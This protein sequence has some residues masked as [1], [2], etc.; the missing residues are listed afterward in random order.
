[1]KS[2]FLFVSKRMQSFAMPIGQT[3]INEH[4]KDSRNHLPWFQ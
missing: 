1:M 3:K 4:G 2:R